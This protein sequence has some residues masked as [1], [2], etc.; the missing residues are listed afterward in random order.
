[1]KDL[2][3]NY[4]LIGQLKIFV[5]GGLGKG[6]ASQ[7]LQDNHTDYLYFHKIELCDKDTKRCALNYS[8]IKLKGPKMKSDILADATQ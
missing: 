8:I 1:L 2:L 6:S 7:S 5:S 3:V 4:F